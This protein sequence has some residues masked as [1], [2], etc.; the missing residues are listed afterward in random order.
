MTCSFLLPGRALAVLALLSPLPLMSANTLASANALA[1]AKVHNN[2]HNNPPHKTPGQTSEKAPDKAGDRVNDMASDKASRDPFKWPFASN[3]IWNMPIGSDAVYI[4][5][6]LAPVPGNDKWAPMPQIDDEIIVLEPDAPL[7]PVYK[8]D[9]AWTGKDRCQATGDLLL[10][11]RMPANY[12]V[13][14]NNKNNCATFLTADR[15]TLLQAQPF[16]RCKQ[17]GPATS[18]VKFPPVDIYGDGQ[19]GAHG[20]SGLSAFGG[21]LRLGELRPGGPPPRHALKVDVYAKQALYACRNKESC[22]RWP[23]IGADR[24]AVGHYGTLKL[25]RAQPFNPNQDEGP[26]SALK[27]GA[28]LAIPANKNL[29]SMGL[30]T[31]PGKM[32]AWTFQNYGAYIVDD[33]WGASFALT[34]ETGPHGSFRDQFKA[35][36]GFELEQRVRDNS[37]WTRDLQRIVAALAV[38]DNNGPDSIGGGGTPLQP[39]AP[40]LHEPPRTR[41]KPPHHGQGN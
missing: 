13:P 23:A 33:T 36:W 10:E 27:M 14:H 21:T 31:E 3:S 5:A 8:S 16:T 18:L 38:V 39:L 4:P 29:A 19:R 30:E 37:Q 9:A 17:E 40:P 32:L 25:G 1:S 41:P 11:V 15:R 20:G 34:A 2:P 12:V 28:L 7:T 22:Y 26:H 6:K 24:Y 35:D